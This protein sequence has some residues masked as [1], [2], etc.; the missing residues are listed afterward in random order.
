[1]KAINIVWDTDEEDV[2]LPSEMHVPDILLEEDEDVS[3][4]WLSDQTGYCIQEWGGL[5]DD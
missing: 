4:Y 3:T 2:N 5:V 1:M